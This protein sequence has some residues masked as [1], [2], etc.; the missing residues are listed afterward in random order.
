M[1]HVACG[2]VSEELWTVEMTPWARGLATALTEEQEGAEQRKR[3]AFQAER[4]AYAK[5]QR[6]ENM[7]V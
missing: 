5:A 3:K 1:W 2:W 7:G 4:T 6:W